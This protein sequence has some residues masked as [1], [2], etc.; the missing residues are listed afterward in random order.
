MREILNSIRGDLS[1]SRDDTRTGGFY[2]IS[3][4]LLVDLP[5]MVAYIDKSYRYLFANKSYLRWF[6][7]E[8]DPDQVFGMSVRDVVGEKQFAISEPRLKMAFDGADEQ[9]ERFIREPDGSLRYMLMSYIP[10]FDAGGRVG[11]VYVIATDITRLKAAERKLEL[12]ASVFENIVDGV[13]VTNGDGVVVAVNSSFYEITGYSEIETIGQTPR[14]LKSG[15]HDQKF[16]EKMWKD[17]IESKRWQG[18][19]WNRRK[20]GE[21]YLEWL[22]ITAIVDEFGNTT[23]YVAV[24][25]DISQSHRNIDQVVHLAYHDAL[26]D[27]P[28]RYLLMERLEHLFAGCPREGRRLAVMFLD[29]DGF[30]PINDAFG[31]AV[32]DEA[33]KVVARR[34]SA[35]V[36]EN[37]T[38]ARVGGDEFVIL[39]ENGTE[40]GEVEAISRRLFRAV[41]EPIEVNDRILGVGVSIGVA[42]GPEA[43]EQ[44]GDLIERADRAMYETKKNRKSRGAVS[45]P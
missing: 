44:P 15:R 32:G 37:D 34:L 27:L 5:F 3:R 4:R 45:T 22:S 2:H 21:I 25:N 23:S 16:Y 36:R 24:F 6:G 13:A 26:T 12:A 9:Y 14:I 18:E 1:N 31:H 42:I 38:V 43:G 20:N 10:D 29:L 11:A 35:A 40:I 8:F 41:V 7:V 39:L 33:L 17:L 30:K 28:N 19:I